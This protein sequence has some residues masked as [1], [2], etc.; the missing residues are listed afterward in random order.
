[1]N[2]TRKIFKTIILLLVGW[3]MAWIQP[4]K[5]TRCLPRLRSRA[6]RGRRK[7]RDLARGQTQESWQERWRLSWC[8]F[9][10]DFSFIRH[11]WVLSACFEH[12]WAQNFQNSN[13]LKVEMWSLHWEVPSC[14]ALSCFASQ[15]SAEPAKA[16]FADRAPSGCA[17]SNLAAAAAKLFFVCLGRAQG[18]V[19]TRS[20]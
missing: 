12:V 15:E 13:L 16:Q 3:F 11:S 18:V 8:Q 7:S 20:F 2:T 19:F 9:W 5:N 1:M 10:W 4:H 6:F 17:A 14:L